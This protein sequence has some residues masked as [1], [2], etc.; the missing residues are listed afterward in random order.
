VLEREFPPDDIDRMVKVARTELR[1]RFLA[2]GVG[3]S[4]ANALIAEGG[5]VM[6]V[7]NEGNNRMSVALPRSTS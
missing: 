2:S 3:L 6:L 7:C 5:S 1:Q 4:G